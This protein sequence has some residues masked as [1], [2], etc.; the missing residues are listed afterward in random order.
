MMTLMYGKIGLLGYEN[1]ALRK[2]SPTADAFQR[3]TTALAGVREMKRVEVPGQPSIFLFEVDRSPRG[4]VYVVWERR[5]E[6]SGEDSPAVRFDC[7]ARIAITRRKHHAPMGGGK[8]HGRL[9]RWSF[10]RR[11][12]NRIIPKES[13]DRRGEIPST[14]TYCSLVKSK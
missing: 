2:R 6:F 5:D 12:H 14:L 11:S 4:P 8:P 1:G 9:R 13:R 7:F 3:M 10:A